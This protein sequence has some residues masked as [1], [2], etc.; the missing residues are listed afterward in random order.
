M[1]H[2]VAITHLKERIYVAKQCT[3]IPVGSDRFPVL[4]DRIVVAVPGRQRLVSL[5]KEA[6]FPQILG[7]ASN[8]RGE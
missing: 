1:D 6:R 8:R 5:E 3:S 4:G 7:G 2:T